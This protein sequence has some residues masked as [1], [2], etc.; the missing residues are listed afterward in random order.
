MKDAVFQKRCELA[1]GRCG[2]AGCAAPSAGWRR[3]WGG[4]SLY[5]V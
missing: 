2:R 1:H 5:F 3:D 4:G